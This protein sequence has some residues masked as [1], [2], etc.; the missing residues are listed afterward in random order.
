MTNFIK[1][2]VR[3]LSIP[4][5][6]QT[7]LKTITIALQPFVPFTQQYTME[8]SKGIG[9]K[10]AGP[11][12]E[13]NFNIAP[14]E[15]KRGDPDWKRI[16]GDYQAR[17]PGGTIKDMI[18]NTPHVDHLLPPLA[19]R[20]TELL[21]QLPKFSQPPRYSTKSVYGEILGEMPLGLVRDIFNTAGENVP[22]SSVKKT[23]QKIL[24]KTLKG[25]GSQAMDFARSD[26]TEPLFQLLGTMFGKS[27]VQGSVAIEVTDSK[28]KKEISTGLEGIKDPEKAWAQMQKTI[29]NKYGQIN[30]AFEMMYKALDKKDK[31]SFD[32]ILKGFYGTEKSGLNKAVLNARDANVNV[33]VINLL[34]Q[35]VDRFGRL[36][37]V[38][39]A[40]GKDIAEAYNYLLPL[41]DTG[42]MVG[43]K[44]GPEWS[45][46]GYPQ[47]KVLQKHFIKVGGD[48]RLLD[49][50][51]AFEQKKLTSISIFTDDYEKKLKVLAANDKINSATKAQFINMAMAAVIDGGVLDV[52][53]S[54]DM[55]KPKHG[56]KLGKPTG[57]MKFTSSE[58]AAL[59]AP[60]FQALKDDP[61]AGGAVADA[62]KKIYKLANTA[63]E[64][65]KKKVTADQIDYN[66]LGTQTKGNQGVW[67]AS[68]RNW[69]DNVADPTGYNV[70]MV[71]LTLSQAGPTE[72]ITTKNVGWVD[73]TKSQKDAGKQ[74][75][76]ETKEQEDRRRGK[77][78]GDRQRKGIDLGKFNAEEFPTFIA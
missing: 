2:G 41:G 25:F 52:D 70:G 17:E 9:G 45:T 54:V 43:L 19:K 27:F 57:A 39:V 56:D 44:L 31:G 1:A 50:Y 42:H 38:N 37:A 6:A 34:N 77:F 48:A 14:V 66:Y 4:A 3:E 11:L 62:W 65:W 33:G 63:S 23:H 36:N 7:V 32:S 18:E 61:A 46:E 29:E 40:E 16:L 10:A 5:H 71:P 28:F 30:K 26:E 13:G 12:D 8:V 68:G 35:F 22:G 47:M 59:L 64:L 51:R 15:S 49:L 60:Q 20:L 78:I 69:P 72:R 74:W 55:W 75:T 67:T 21:E 24:S 53:T 76:I 73:P 58:I